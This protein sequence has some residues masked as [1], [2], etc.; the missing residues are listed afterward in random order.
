MLR[1]VPLCLL[2]AAGVQDAKPDARFDELLRIRRD[3]RQKKA[4]SAALRLAAHAA[5]DRADY[6]TAVEKHKEAAA[7]EA[8]AGELRKKEAKL[9]PDLVTDLVQELMDDAIDVRQRAMIRLLVVGAAAVPALQEVART[10]D[11]DARLLAESVLAQLRKC[12]VDEEGRLQQWAAKASAS[13][14]YGTGT[15]GWSAQQATGKPDTDVGGDAQTAWASEPQD[16]DEEWIELTY[17]HA[18]RPTRVR[19]HETF[20]PGAV[21]KIE[22]MDPAGKWR[23]LWSGADP[24]KDCPGWLDVRFDAPDFPTKMIRLTID[25]DTVKGWNE[26]DA[27]QLVGWAENPAAGK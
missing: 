20:N 17:P 7:R 8:E 14:E 12:G 13:S 3:G 25:S 24:T 27:V 2:I 15:E 1:V 6:E 16:A 5:L 9:V 26:I 11:A 10:G 19:V 18:V 4:A 23:T 21:V 22:A